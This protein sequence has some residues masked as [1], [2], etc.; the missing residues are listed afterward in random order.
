MKQEEELLNNDDIIMIHG[1]G[2]L[3]VIISWIVK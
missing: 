3:D 2:Y 1:Q